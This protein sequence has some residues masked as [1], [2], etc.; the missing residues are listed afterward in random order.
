MEK[1]LF[2]IL[3]VLSS[4]SMADDKKLDDNDIHHPTISVG[5][6]S[7]INEFTYYDDEKNLAK[8][9]DKVSSLNKEKRDALEILEKVDSFYSK[10][11][12]TLLLLITTIIGIVGVVIPL[13][14][15]SYQTRLLKKQ[16]SNL[17]ISIDNEF[18]I[19]LSNL[20]DSI[21]EYNKNEMLKLEGD[22]RDVMMKIEANYK[23]E[24]EKLRAESLAKI[25]HHSATTCFVSGDYGLAALLF[26][27]AGLY[28]MSYGYHKNL[29]IVIDSLVKSV[30]IN[31]PSNY[32]SA[33]LYEVY[34]QFMEKLSLF[35]TDLIYSNDVVNL[36][37][38]WNEFEK[39]A[40]VKRDSKP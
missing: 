16:N 13:V 34:D 33:L 10:S 18:S 24:I 8:L 20:K 38:V 37:S 9:A 15:S 11:F 35:D 31:I 27:N 39:R 5:T 21:Y 36:K 25:N 40:E 7:N 4:N 29:R 12:N 22:V 2:L 30:V 32:D 3:A 1:I 26:F 23:V 19:K 6:Q 17:K 28:Y 14:I